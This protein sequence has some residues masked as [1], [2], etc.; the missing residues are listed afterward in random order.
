MNKILFI[1]ISTILLI[2]LIIYLD[3]TQLLSEIK[4]INSSTILIVIFL[5]NISTILRAMKW[6][7]LLDNVT[8]REILPIQLLSISISNLTPGKIAEP[9]KSVLLKMKK[10][11][12]ISKTLPSVILE[13]ILDIFVLI[14]LS[15]LGILISSEYLSSKFLIISVVAFTFLLILMILVL[16]YKSFGVR[17]FHFLKNFRFFSF[18]DENFINNFYSATKIKSK[19]IISSSL[20]TFLAW[21]IDGLI[22][23]FI[24]LSINKELTVNINLWFF[25]STL[26]ISIVASLL[27]FLPGGIGGTEAL[28]TYIL[29]SIGFERSTA[30]AIVLVGRFATL[31]YSMILG[32]L[33]FIY[34]SKVLKINTNTLK[35]NKN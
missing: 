22:F 34:L 29:I 5:A 30:G 16:I 8:L 7:V 32:Y 6:K 1:L 14:I 19:K 27:T 3:P 26:A 15:I 18:L 31:G 21:I 9:I 20:L 33:S 12:A 25:F 4:K 17:I 23:Y 2:L 13:R 35:L 11:V 10:G 24:A 28:M